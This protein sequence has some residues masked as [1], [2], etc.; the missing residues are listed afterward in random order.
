M[1]SIKSIKDFKTTQF[2]DRLKR[3][4]QPVVNYDS[5]FD[6]LILL[7]VPIETETVV[8]YIDSN[9]G[10]LYVPETLEIVGLQIEDFE[11]DFIPRHEEV[12]KVW[13][14]SDSDV[15]K[16]LGDLGELIFVV[17]KRKKEVAKEV[18]RSTETLLSDSGLELV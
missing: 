5:V 18:F 6:A 4:I 15:P 2:V 17:D 1:D 9:V 10:L 12:R 13:R 3:K 11:Y 8:H 7:F 14:L 16:N